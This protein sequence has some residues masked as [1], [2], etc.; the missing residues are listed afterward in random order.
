MYGLK[1]APRARYNE[2]KNFVLS[3]G[4]SNAQSDTL[5]IYAYDGIIA[6][7]LVYV[8][9]LILIGKHYFFFL[10]SFV[11]RLSTRFPIKDLRALH[12][13]LGMKVGRIVF[14]A[15][16]GPKIKEWSI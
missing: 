12:Y 8:D 14:W 16:L 13:F 7:L 3:T 10:T 1:Q 6:Y 15:Q 4:F 11:Q 9:N 2:L 5:F